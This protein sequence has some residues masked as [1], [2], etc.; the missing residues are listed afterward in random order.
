MKLTDIGRVQQLANA[1]NDAVRL[2]AEVR[3]GHGLRIALNGIWLDTGI[4]T[5]CRPVVLAYFREQVEVAE[6]GLRELGIEVEP[7]LP[8]AGPIAIQ[9]LR[10]RGYA[11][12]Q[13]GG[14]C[15]AW[16]KRIDR[17]DVVVTDL[18]GTHEATPDDWIVGRY[19]ADDWG[20]NRMF[21]ITSDE[22]NAERGLFATLDLVESRTVAELRD[23]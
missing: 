9:A 18:S 19:P 22:A 14:G 8:P 17:E 3:A 13:T 4:V 16:V 21:C 1:R 11:I 2:H 20:S 23:M 6:R 10:E 12:Q 15:T 7:A 5:H